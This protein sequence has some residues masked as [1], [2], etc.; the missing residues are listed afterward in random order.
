MD[1]CYKWTRTRK[2]DLVREE[3]RKRVDTDITD[4]KNRKGFVTRQ[5]ILVEILMD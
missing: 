1:I 2:T 4:A 3:S 5:P